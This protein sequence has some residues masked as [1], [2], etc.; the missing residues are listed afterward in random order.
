MTFLS[1]MVIFEFS[2]LSR[3]DTSLFGA[4]QLQNR[5]SEVTTFRPL[6]LTASL[7]EP[8][9]RKPSSLPPLGQVVSFRS[10]RLQLE[11]W[12]FRSILARQFWACGFPQVLR[13]TRRTGGDWKF[14]AIHCYPWVVMNESVFV[15]HFLSHIYQPLTSQSQKRWAAFVLGFFRQRSPGFGG[16]LG[17]PQCLRG[18]WGLSQGQPNGHGGRAEVHRRRGWSGLGIWEMNISQNRKVEDKKIWMKLGWLLN[19]Q[20]A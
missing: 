18:Q 5:R 9:R 13:M 3:Q 19:H 16:F 15:G 12:P 2:M 8:R 17:P 7:L 20:K 10:F 6:C 4:L 14:D 1:K 11:L